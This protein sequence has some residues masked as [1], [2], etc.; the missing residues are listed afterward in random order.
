M[1]QPLTSCQHLWSMEARAASHA[2]RQL[3]EDGQHSEAG[4]RAADATELA[5]LAFPG[6]SRGTPRGSKRPTRPPESRRGLPEP[7]TGCSVTPP[8]S[9]PHQ[10]QE[11][12]PLIS[13]EN[14]SCPHLQ[15]VIHGSV[16][17]IDRRLDVYV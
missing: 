8:I 12:R 6:R 13:F 10:Q 17:K 5:S 4:G 9:K 16:G 11:R 3:R 14:W 7:F 1:R 2:A 15:A